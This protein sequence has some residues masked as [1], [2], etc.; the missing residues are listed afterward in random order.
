MIIAIVVAVMFIFSLYN[1]ISTK[2]S[3]Y[4]LLKYRIEM[5]TYQL[6]ST[7][8][9]FIES[10]SIREYDNIL[11]SYIQSYESIYAFVV[12][13][14]KMSE[15]LGKKNPYYL[16]KIRDEKWHIKSL[17]SDNIDNLDFQKSFYSSSE[18]IYSQ[19]GELIGKI[20]IFA[21]DRFVKNELNNMIINSI[22]ATLLISLLLSLGLY[23][24]L[25]IVILKPINSVINAISKKDEDGIPLNPLIE[26]NSLEMEKL[27]DSLNEMRFSIKNSRNS[28]IKLNKEL[29]FSKDKYQKLM[30]FASD[31]IL[32]L[33]MKGKLIECSNQVKSELGYSAEEIKSL[34]LSDWNKDIKESEIEKSLSMISEEPKTIE[35]VHTRK[36]GSTFMVEMLSV[37]ITIDNT[38]YI[39]SSIRNIT[40]R[41]EIE[42][43]IKDQKEEFEA[44]FNY[45]TEGIAILDLDSKFLN[46]NDAYVQMLGYTKEQLLTMNC[47]DLTVSEDRER[48]KE[49]LNEALEKGY[50]KNFEK[51]SI[52][53]GGKRINVAISIS[54][55]PDKK[56]FLLMSKDIS[57]E[58]VLQEQARLAS[59]GEMIGNIAHQ[60]RQPLSVISVSV[61]SVKLQAELEKLEK[62]YIMKCADDVMLQTE[63]LSKTID[64]F[65]DFIR[66]KKEYGLI[67]LVETIHSSLSLLDASL[68]NNFI[69]LVLDLE[70]DLTIIGNKNELSEA[71]IN[72]VNNSK[73]ILKSYSEESRYL[74]IS[75]KS[76]DENSL[77]LTILDSGGGIEDSILSRVFEPYFTTKHKS[78]GTGL[79]LAI[80]EKII[81]QRHGAVITVYNKEFTYDKRDFKGACF[82]IVFKK[83]EN[84]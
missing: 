21:S 68:N 78:Q 2:D 56:R 46:I 64:N 31:M 24:V 57:S 39:Y 37:K 18:N 44:V 66:G 76:L 34:K 55:L 5:A 13:D 1:Y 19:S 30:S 27:S 42:K 45:S 58:K 15:I 69:K 83:R 49:A 82:S 48:T 62:T 3:L 84:E 28:L 51:S 25:R 74:F 11:I 73:D 20:T 26:P 59:M 32:V 8:A 40:K 63:Y 79:G 61:S 12:E 29:K 70:D 52:I 71:I 53:K 6:K 36:D 4:T 60:W 35:A 22:G 33:D 43:R 47:L 9:Y 23:I 38:N 50:I 17:K 10:Y 65:R 72:I 41:K 16:V 75:T 14:Y 80:T 81:R 77:E 67:S 7:I 54:L